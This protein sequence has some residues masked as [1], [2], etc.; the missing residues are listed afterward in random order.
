MRT[1]TRFEPLSVMKIVGM[2][3]GMMGLVLGAI[4]SLVFLL[5]APLIPEGMPIFFRLLFGVFSVF[6]L[7]IFYGAIGALMA[8]LGAAIYNVVAK[9]IG[10]IQV[11]VQ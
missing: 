8:G 1:V 2:C 3:Y 7:P 4:V 10:G 9:W 5:S 6:V 11:E